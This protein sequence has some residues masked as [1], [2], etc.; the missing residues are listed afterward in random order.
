MKKH[1][2]ILNG[3][4]LKEQFPK[5]IEGEI[6]IARECL[7]DGPVKCDTLEELFQLRA[8]F[9]AEFYD[10]YPIDKYYTESVPEFEK[11]RAI[12]AESMV[13]LWFEDDLFCQVNFWFVVYLLFNSVKDCTVFYIR[14]AIHTQYGFGGLDGTEII[15]A[16]KE[17]I[18]ITEMDKI[19]SLWKSYQNNDTEKLLNTAKELEELYPFV[20]QAVEAHIAR[21]P[22]EN[23]PGKPAQSLI[24]IMKELE[25]EEFSP[26]FR[27]FNKRESIYGYGDMQV[28]RLF[29]EIKKNHQ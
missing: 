17:R 3:D 20:V 22:H 10:I 23:N 27:E 26:V 12:P 13:Y 16:F 18:Q 28:K 24:E 6:I 19:S 11:I 8:T 14:P 25:T 5:E 2:H 4:C 15:E 29:D 9:M 1:F 21:I 7:V